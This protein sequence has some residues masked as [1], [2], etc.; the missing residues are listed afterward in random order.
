[1]SL[2][3]NYVGWIIYDIKQKGMEYLLNIGKKRLNWAFLMHEFAKIFI[4]DKYRLKTEHFFFYW[5]LI[6]INEVFPRTLTIFGFSCR[7]SVKLL[8]FGDKIAHSKNAFLVIKVYY[9]QFLQL[10]TSNKGFLPTSVT[11]F[12]SFFFKF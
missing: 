5:S 2:N 12:Y 9:H 11:V 4:D 8:L 6:L 7:I 1:M 3:I 10:T